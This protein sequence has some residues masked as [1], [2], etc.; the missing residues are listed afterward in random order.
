ME[1]L[2]RSVHNN[3]AALHTTRALVSPAQNNEPPNRS[4]QSAQ[5]QTLSLPATRSAGKVADERTDGNP[6]HQR[7][8]SDVHV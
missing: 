7:E 2:A 6:N 5:R 8:E 1:A 3:A 4:D